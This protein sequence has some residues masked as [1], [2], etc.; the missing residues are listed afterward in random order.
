M[1]DL[2]LARL[3]EML[4]Y[5]EHTGDFRWLR[6]SKFH[7]EKVGHLAGSVRP[8]RAGRLYRVIGID[9]R[10]LK[11]HRLAWFYVHGSWPGMIDHMNGD[12]LDNRICNL[13]EVTHFENTQNHVRKPKASGLPTGVSTSRD[14]FRSRITVNGTVVYLGVFASPEAAHQ[15]YTAARKEMHYCPATDGGGE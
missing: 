9:G 12:P 14:G 2:D 13:R 8:S 7:A 10:S 1:S 6:P 15:A 5:N 11:A 4:D 3:R